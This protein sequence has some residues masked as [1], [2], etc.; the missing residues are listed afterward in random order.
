LLMYLVYLLLGSGIITNIFTFQKGSNS[1]ERTLFWLTL[2]FTGLLVS[3]VIKRAVGLE[4]KEITPFLGFTGRMIGR[5]VD[6]TL[7]L[8]VLLGFIGLKNRKEEKRMKK[9]VWLWSCITLGGFLLWYFPL[10]P[11]NNA[12]LTAFGFLKVA[13]EFIT[14]QQINTALVSW[15]TVVIMTGI[16]IGTVIVTYKLRNKLTFYKVFA[17]LA[18]F[19]TLTSAASIAATAYNA[20]TWSK[21][22]QMVLSKWLSTKIDKGETLLVDKK[23]CNPRMSREDPKYLCTK[24][25][26]MS[27]VGFWLNNRIIVSNPST[28]SAEYIVT[29]D[30][31]DKEL[32]KETKNGI[33]VYK[34]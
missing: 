13:I 15:S 25:K 32:I 17:C 9:S 24:N 11:F 3:V 16:I 12:S 31:L 34:Q 30:S 7:P 4:V 21:S 8:I 1:K 18:I 6:F 14:T 27:Y 20:N 28:T 19:F 2:A 23:F 29:R 22:E 5:Y 10:F 26:Q 33:K